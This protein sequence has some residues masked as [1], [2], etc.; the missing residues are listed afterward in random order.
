MPNTATIILHVFISLVLLAASAY[1]FLE[2][3]MVVAGKYTGH[4]YEFQ[5]PAN[6]VISISLFLLAAFFFLA[7]IQSELMKK[8]CQWLLI[9]SLIVFGIGFFM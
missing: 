6:I 4:L 3:K 1:V 9:T 7:L 8:I 2:K 5:S